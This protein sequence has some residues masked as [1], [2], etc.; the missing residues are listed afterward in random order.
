[1]IRTVYLYLF[2]VLGLVLITIGG[3]G[4]VDMLLKGAVFRRADDEQRFYR[5]EALPPYAIEKAERSAGDPGLNEAERAALRQ[6]ADESRDWRERQKSFDPVRARRERDASRNLALL[7]IG[8]PLYLFHWRIIRREA[9]AARAE[10][11]G[12][13]P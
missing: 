6:W 4:S 12:K 13:T 5:P 2:A 8:L 10:L 3:V 7:A 9:E 11:V 1:M